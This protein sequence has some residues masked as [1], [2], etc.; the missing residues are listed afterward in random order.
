MFLGKLSDSKATEFGNLII[1]IVV[2][3]PSSLTPKQQSEL[4]Q[5]L[6]E[7]EIP[8][9]PEANPD[10]TFSVDTHKI[11]NLEQVGTFQRFMSY[12]QNRKS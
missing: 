7:Q 4:C 2:D 6:P 10:V 12:Q 3:Y 9:R 5:I 8:G 1:D 11:T